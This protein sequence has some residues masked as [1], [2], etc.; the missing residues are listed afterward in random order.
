MRAEK[1]A[2][3]ESLQYYTLLY[4]LQYCAV[5]YDTALYDLVSSRV[6]GIIPQEQGHCQVAL[7]HLYYTS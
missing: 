7:V 2:I 1:V 5:L 6:S 4:N 3:S